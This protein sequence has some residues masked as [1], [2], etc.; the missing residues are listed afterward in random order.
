MV[1]G[2]PNRILIVLAMLVMTTGCASLADSH[3]EHTQ[4]L[5]TQIACLKHVWRTEQD[6]GR[7]YR[8]GW[9][10]GYYDVTTGGE[11]TPPLFAPHDYW[12]PFQVAKYGDQKRAQ[13]YAGFQAGAAQAAQEPDTHYLKLWA[14]SAVCPSPIYYPSAT[15]LPLQTPPPAPPVDPGLVPPPPA[16]NPPAP[17]KSPSEYNQV[18]PSPEQPQRIPQEE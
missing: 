14:P 15:E 2:V 17:N 10:A 3:Y 16:Q 12:S 6:C 18:P 1:W 9:K 7:D 4:K 5:R 8:S 11:G 13:W